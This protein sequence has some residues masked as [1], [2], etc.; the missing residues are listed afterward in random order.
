[1]LEDKHKIEEKAKHALSKLKHAIKKY[2][3]DLKK[4][5]DKFDKSDND[6][7]DISEFG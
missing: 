3:I 1:V 5:F 6:S 2:D 7:L 4:L